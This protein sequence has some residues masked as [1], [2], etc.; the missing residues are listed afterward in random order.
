MTSDHSKYSC[1]P[2]SST[3][4]FIYCYMIWAPCI[5]WSERFYSR[6]D[7]RKR[8]SREVFF[9]GIK[10][11]NSMLSIFYRWSIFTFLVNYI[12]TTN[13]IFTWRK[14]LFY[15]MFMSTVHPMMGVVEPRHTELYFALVVDNA[16]VSCKLLL[17]WTSDNPN[18]CN[19]PVTNFLKFA[20]A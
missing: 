10:Q 19:N 1:T 18:L 20:S 12:Y 7:L 11:R 15:L 5:L 2:L 13:P 6:L 9:P 16:T 3:H 8:T 4:P 17:Q 14:F